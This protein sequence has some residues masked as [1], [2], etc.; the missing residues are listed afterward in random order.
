MGME[1]E[2]RWRKFVTS[3]YVSIFSGYICYNFRVLFVLQFAV[4]NS[5]IDGIIYKNVFAVSVGV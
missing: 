2:Y 3:A 4:D 5:F 1:K